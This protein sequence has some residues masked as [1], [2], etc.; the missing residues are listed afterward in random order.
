MQ[1]RTFILLFHHSEP[2]NLVGKR[3]FQLDLSIL[4]LFVDTLTES[5]LNF[6][7]FRKKN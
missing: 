3:H 6:D 4:G 7:H 1:K 2:K 5:T